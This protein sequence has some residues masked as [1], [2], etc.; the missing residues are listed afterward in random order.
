MTDK[1]KIACYKAKINSLNDEIAGFTGKCEA[2]KQ[3]KEN[4]ERTIE[5]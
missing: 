3:D 4:L 5:E 1:Q 2:L